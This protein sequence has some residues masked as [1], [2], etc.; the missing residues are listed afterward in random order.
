MN[1][2]VKGVLSLFIATVLAKII[3]FT[4]E[5]VLVSTYGASMISDVYIT[6]MN[7]PL[8]LFDIIASAISTTFIPMFFKIQEQNV[9][10]ETLEFT[11]NIFNITVIIGIMLS[12]ISYIFA[13]PLVKVFAVEFTGE[14]LE[15]AIKFTRIIVFSMAFIG[16]SKILSSW[17]QI[18]G[19]FYIPGIISIPSNLIIISSILLS[20]KYGIKIL[21]IGSLI[22]TISQFIFQLPFA[23]K[24]G[25]RYKPY[26]NFKDERIKEIL[27]LIL[28][29]IIGVG[30]AQLNTV[31]D[32]SLAST[33]GDGMITILNSAS[34]FEGVI[35]MLFVTTIVSV[36]YPIISKLSSE[37]DSE[38]FNLSI[39]RSIN[40]II[41]T[42]I[43]ITIGTIVF[44]NPLIS[45]VFERGKFDTNSTNLTAIALSYYSI[46]MVG[47]AIKSILD[48][49]FYSLKDTKT[50]MV[51]GALA[52]GI[53]IL[54]NLILINFMGY[55]GL[56]L[57]TSISSIICAILLFRKLKYKI[58]YFG[59]DKI[60]MTLMK[61]IAAASLMGILVYF[62]DKFIKLNFYLNKIEEIAMLF[63]T[64]FIGALVYALLIKVMK[65]EE[66]EI[67]L[68]RFK[69]KLEKCKI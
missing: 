9:E 10:G 62:I 48:K 2:L 13:E 53:N 8:T 43:P 41:I 46:G 51:N 20:Y 24:T 59:Q 5:A 28:P 31:I 34:K 23:Y 55:R 39:Q 42:M 32:R 33:L 67:L 64:I 66:F 47:L 12:I 36:M 63:T 49:V 57:A 4:R 1:K 50:P 27:V 16:L 68:E 56:A 17:L 69:S 37:D 3:G 11:N 25:Y 65:I 14:K 26:I 38:E 52:M 35:N 40:I 22:G 45:L 6:T 54:L 7:I 15:L 60:T 44:S 61:C 21:I 18:K 19:N 30:V 58:G 29:V